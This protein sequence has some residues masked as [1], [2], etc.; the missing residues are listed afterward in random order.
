MANPLGAATG[1]TE[2]IQTNGSRG[3]ESEGAIA[4]GGN[5]TA[6]RHDRRHAPAGLAPP[7]SYP[8]LVVNGTSNSFNLQKGSAYVP[9]RTGNVNFNGGG[10]YLTTAPIDFTAAFTDLTAQVHHLGRGTDRERLGH[11]RQHLERQ[12]HRHSLGGNSSLYLK[13]TDATRNVFS[14]TPAQLTGNSATS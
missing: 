14:V 12:R 9:G 10:G 4:Y 3:S 2:F 1:Y 6:S 7:P 5:L 11:G 8:S 13:G